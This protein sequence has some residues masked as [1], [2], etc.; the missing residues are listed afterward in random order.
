MESES[1]KS[2]KMHAARGEGVVIGRGPSEWQ[3]GWSR[4]TQRKE[5]H[6]KRKSDGRARESEGRDDTDGKR[7]TRGGCN[8][9]RVRDRADASARARRGTPMKKGKRGGTREISRG[10]ERARARVKAGGQ[11]RESAQ[12]RD[13]QRERDGRICV[14]KQTFDQSADCCQSYVAAAYPSVPVAGPRIQFRVFTRR[15]NQ[16]SSVRAATRENRLL[17]VSRA[18]LRDRTRAS[19]NLTLV[20]SQPEGSVIVGVRQGRAA[21]TPRPFPPAT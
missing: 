17:N 16:D 20:S 3:R 2:A 1:E 6:R 8:R 9:K 13:R 14:L 19:S 7:E 21:Q 18:V 4:S 10:S 11:E 12:R 15:G 5:R